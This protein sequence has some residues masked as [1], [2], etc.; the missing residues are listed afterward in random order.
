MV[1]KF[2]FLS[3]GKRID[4]GIHSCLASEQDLSVECCDIYWPALKRFSVFAG[5]VLYPWYS[6][7]GSTAFE[8][9]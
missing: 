6:C 3:R 1:G 7:W 5:D 4:K 9:N 2:F 8:S